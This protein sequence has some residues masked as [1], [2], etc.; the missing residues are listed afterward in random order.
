M[1]TLRDIQIIQIII[2]FFFLLYFKYNLFWNKYKVILCIL[3]LLVYL[4]S[5][6]CNIIEISSNLSCLYLT[7]KIAM[8]CQQKLLFIIFIIN[9]NIVYY[10]N[11]NI[12]IIVF[13]KMKI[14]IYDIDYIVNNSQ[15]MIISLLSLYV[16]Y[17]FSKLE[18]V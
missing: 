12:I 1:Y 4:Y 18:R 6:S 2:K 11:N 3:F 14:F 13:S 7:R 15:M 8:Q 10:N 5:L 17:L 9:I 16:F